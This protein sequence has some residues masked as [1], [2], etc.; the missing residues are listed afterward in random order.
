MG[1][2]ETLS[3]TWSKPRAL[4]SMILH[5]AAALDWLV[6]FVTAIDVFDLVVSI[7]QPTQGRPPQ[8]TVFLQ[9]IV[10]LNLAHQWQ[11]FCVGQRVIDNGSPIP[12]QAT[13][14]TVSRCQFPWFGQDQNRH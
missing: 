1:R 2:R 11:P 14:R 6:C 3:P 10:V 13:Q 7:S 5:S 12:L 4:V 8:V 9:T